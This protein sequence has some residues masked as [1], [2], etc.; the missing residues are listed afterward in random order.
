MSHHDFDF[1][2]P[3][4]TSAVFAKLLLVTFRLLSTLDLDCTRSEMSL[5]DSDFARLGSSSA[6]FT[7]L[8]LVACGPLST[9][10]LSDIGLET[11][12]FDYDFDR[13]EN[14]SALFTLR[15]RMLLDL[16]QCQISATLVWDSFIGNVS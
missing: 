3:G 11:N 4:N 6:I 8:L 13:P 1:D 16:L 14:S 9:S 2:R 7:T 10:H 5:L 12:H 15:L